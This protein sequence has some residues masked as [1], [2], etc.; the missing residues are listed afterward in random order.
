MS[1]EEIAQRTERGTMIF[2]KIVIFSLLFLVSALSG[3]VY[4]SKRYLFSAF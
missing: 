4:P 3:G 2:R 1:A